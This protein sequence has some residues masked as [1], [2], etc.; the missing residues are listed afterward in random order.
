MLLQCNVMVILSQS[1]HI[2]KCNV[3][4]FYGKVNVLVK[5]NAIVILFAH[6]IT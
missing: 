4:L 1:F 3:E 2:I 6:L 5:S